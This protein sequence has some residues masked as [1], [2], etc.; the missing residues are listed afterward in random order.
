MVYSLDGNANLTLNGNITLTDLS[1]GAH[2]ASVWANDTSG[3]VGYSARWFSVNVTPPIIFYDNFDYASIDELKSVWEPTLPG[4]FIFGNGTL[5][6]WYQGTFRKGDIPPYSDSDLEM[7]I[8]S[9]SRYSFSVGK[10]TS[11]SVWVD[12]NNAEGFVTV[13]IIN[14]SNPWPGVSMKVGSPAP[15][16]N[17]YV[18]YNIQFRGNSVKV[19]RDGTLIGE[20]TNDGLWGTGKTID[21]SSFSN[22]NSTID[23][24]RITDVAPAITY[25]SPTDANGTT[26]TTRNWTFVNVTLSENG[27]AWLDWN[28]T[29]QSMNGSGTSWY[30]NKTNLSN[31]NYSYRVRVN[32]SAGNWNV[33]ETRTIE[34]SAAP[35]PSPVNW[36]KYSGNPLGDLGTDIGGPSVIFDGTTYKMWY[37]CGS[38]TGYSGDGICYTASS[39]GINWAK[40]GKVMTNGTSN[41][42]GRVYAPSVMFNGTTYKMWYQGS[43]PTDASRGRV[44]YAESSNGINWTKYGLVLNVGGNGGWDDWNIYNPKV[45]FNGTHYLM[46]YAAQA[47]IYQYPHGVGL[48]IS[49][50]GINWTKY[51]ANP[52]FQAGSSGEWDDWEHSPNSVLFD[53]T[54]YH[55]W[56]RA[57]RGANYQKDRIG[58]ANSTNAINWVKYSNN[59]VLSHG[60]PGEWDS[61]TAA[62]GAVIYD[63]ITNTYKMWY[64]GKDGSGVYR[65]GY[66]YSGVAPV[67]PPDTTSPAISRPSDINVSMYAA[68][69][70]S[71]TINDLNPSSYKLFRNGT[72]IA[73]GSY[74]NGQT[75]TVSV[76]TNILGTWNYT[77]WANDTSGNVASDEVLVTVTSTAVYGVSLA[78]EKST[79]SVEQNENATYNITVINTGNANDTFSLSVSSAASSA[80]L[81]ATL[82][83]LNAGN[84]TVVTL[85]VK[86]SKIGSYSTSAKAASQGDSSKYS[87]VSITTNVIPAV[88]IIP[89]AK[90]QSVFIN[91]NAIFNL[92][93]KNTG[94]KDHTFNLSI[95]KDANLNASF[96]ASTVFVPTGNS[97]VVQL[98][99]NS[100]KE[101]VYYATITAYDV[102]DSTI[103]HAVA[104]KLVVTQKVIYGVSLT[105]DKETQTVLKNKNATYNLTLKNTGN[106]NDTY[107][108]I[109]AN[110][111][112]TIAVLDKYAVSMSPGET[113]NMLLTVNSSSGGEYEVSAIAISQNDTSKFASVTTKTKVV[114]YQLIAQIY[115]DSA[116]AY[117]EENVT[118]KLMIKNAGNVNDTAVLSFD[119]LPGNIIANFSQTTLAL[120]AGESKE[121]TI[122][123]SGNV[124]D[125]YNITIDINSAGLGGISASLTVTLNV[126]AESFFDV[127]AA[128]DPASQ[129]VESKENATYSLTVKN[130]GNREDNYTFTVETTAFKYWLDTSVLRLLPGESASRTLTVHNVKPGTYLTTIAVTSQNN[131]S[132]YAEAQAVTEVAHPIELKITPM[133][134]TVIEGKEAEFKLHLKNKGNGE[135]TFNL[136]TSNST[137]AKLDINSTVLRPGEFAEFSLIVNASNG[138]HE[139]TITAFD[140]EDPSTYASTTVRVIVLPGQVYG[141]R[142]QSNKETEIVRPD[143]NATFI[144]TLINLG[145]QN[146]TFDLAI[147]KPSNVNASLSQQNVTLEPY[148]SAG[149]I[150][151][152]WSSEE[153]RHEITVKATSKNNS[154]ASSE[155]KLIVSIS[156]CNVVTAIENSVI[157]NSR[158]CGYGIRDSEIEK[159]RVSYSYVNGSEIDS[160]I[161]LNS[162]ISKSTVKE[163]SLIRNSSISKSTIIK[164]IVRNAT[165]RR[166][167]IEDSIV[168]S[169]VNGTVIEYGNITLYG[170][171]FNISKPINI[172]DIIEAFDEEDQSLAGIENQTL[173]ISGANTTLIIPVNESFV[174]ASLKVVRAS[175]PPRGASDLSVG[176]Y[177]TL[178]ASELLL[179]KSGTI[180]LRIYYD[181]LPSNI[182]TNTL[183]INYYNETSGNWTELPSGVNTAEKYVYA[184]VTHFSVY[185]ISGL[186]TGDGPGGPSGGGGGGGGVPDVIKLSRWWEICFGDCLI[187]Y[188]KNAAKEDVEMANMLLEELKQKLIQWGSSTIRSRVNQDKIKVYNESELSELYLTTNHLILIGGDYANTIT[189]RVNKTNKFERVEGMRW[190]INANNTK[191]VESETGA[192]LEF[193]PSPFSPASRKVLVIAGNTRK[194]TAKAGGYLIARL[195]GEE[196]VNA[197]E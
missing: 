102:A 28:G 114:D 164:S 26:L 146:D 99:L 153:G 171:W 40:Y 159:S 54:T 110:P 17:V 179:N 94:T 89:D 71:W 112:A 21:F 52:V 154:L 14:S 36:T 156:T 2:S 108:L 125:K 67:P 175:I 27:T 178:D 22:S 172:S 60:N 115:P 74:T 75:I 30:L 18:L 169:K 47:V 38:G 19:Y 41:W 69:S 45:V 197:I 166:S 190:K 180:E 70:I 37:S 188:G 141:T 123:A 25:V 119:S 158:I 39:N 132:E 174:G 142:L 134:R 101:G 5:T 73:S 92:T 147:T 196:S 64:L 163:N 95:G 195:V 122:T 137:I 162:T 104:I 189:A 57:N 111:F 78:A 58:Y 33:S 117:A 161:V 49:T 160:S 13:N 131:A 140:A 138:I 31:G 3:N 139:I 167:V 100:S 51:A 113:S 128:I 145:N 127:F 16:I 1:N 84:K 4:N 173:S 9:N 35:K 12:D 107:K 124:S 15:T 82:V 53:G 44:F 109:V 29:N 32:D 65:I 63:N 96:G 143:T 170:A 185:G 187:V 120:E 91:G 177:T 129:T 182:D 85:T 144:L 34:I 151:N 155:V 56:Y 7:L 62:E 97:S 98:L 76:N 136:T 103:A 59:P 106:A 93:I 43:D 88:E 23:W 81:N 79:L 66:A 184:S 50:N 77:V 194:G 183:K 55:L 68:T 8:K 86:D 148:T 118:F 150:L 24:L 193:A 130:T 133:S 61:E 191:Q 176:A 152:I 168:G 135:H 10:G 181:N 11:G 83:S 116:T 42:E 20:T 6:T 105:A 165:I 90:E 186:V 46:I 149:I 48:A 72:L 121:V 87:T 192:T 126:V 80:V 157:K